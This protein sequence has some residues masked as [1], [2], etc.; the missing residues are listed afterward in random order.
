M[1]F[2]CCWLLCVK[3]VTSDCFSS[4]LFPF[5]LFLNAR[6]CS[7]AASKKKTKGSKLNAPASKK[8]SVNLVWVLQN[9]EEMKVFESSV[10]LKKQKRNTRRRIQRTS[11]FVL[12]TLT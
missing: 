5:C 10:D 2:S 1:S 11:M 4:H 12:C 6:A 7:S 9:F 8:I 3:F